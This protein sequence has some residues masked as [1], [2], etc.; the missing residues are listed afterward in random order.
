[1]SKANREAALNDLSSRIFSTMLGEII[2]DAAIQAQ[3]EVVRSRKVCDVCNTRCGQVHE[4]GSATAASTSKAPSPMA[5]DG[6]L[7][8]E[9]STS[10]ARAD[11]NT[12]L[13]CL[14]C[15][16]PIA[17]NR[18]AQHL[19]S[20]M[21]LGTGVRRAVARTAVSKTK[22]GEG[23]RSSSPYVMDSVLDD[24]L[25]DTKTSKSKSKPKPIPKQLGD[26]PGSGQKRPGSPQVSPAKKPKKGRPQV[27]RSNSFIE[28]PRPPTGQRPAPPSSH[29]KGLSKLRGSTPT[30]PTPTPSLVASTR[31]RSR[32]RTGSFDTDSSTSSHGG[33]GAGASAS[34]A[35][36]AGT[37]GGGADDDSSS[38]E[39]S[40]STLASMLLPKAEMIGRNRKGPAGATGSGPPRRPPTSLPRLASPKLP[41]PPV[42]RL[43]EPEYHIDVEGE[44]TGSSSESDS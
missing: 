7:S 20:C 9:S 13:E 11:G 27:P 40:N 43:P 4:P 10:T 26:E 15:Q 21:N 37:G 44:E 29:P 16:R 38:N 25:D 42:H 1:M 34:V 6:V 23:G 3:Q 24:I 14:E 33:Q 32:S 12:L 35:G 28:P 18:F 36:T 41:G 31:S 22:L 19:A 17:S 5:V 39:S 2:M 30:H 8:Q